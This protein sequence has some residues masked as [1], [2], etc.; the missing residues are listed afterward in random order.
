MLAKDTVGLMDVL[1]IEKAH[2]LGIS[3][4]GL[5]AQQIAISYPERVRS[6]IIVSSHFGGPNQIRMDDR[7]LALLVAVPTET[8][9]F[10]QAR[11]MRYMATFTP[12]FLQENKPLMH[13]MDAWAEKYATPLFAQVN[14]SAATNAFDAEAKLSQI[15]APTLI[16]H[17]DQD[18]AVPTE[19]GRLIA[20]RIPNSKLVI[21]KGAPH[22]CIIEKY[23]ELNNEV[24]NFIDEVEKG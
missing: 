12:K 18:K 19:N 7:T 17:G 16:L 14:Q 2:V 1:G 5:V 9:S 24:M 4:G 21:L 8:I 23:E 3:M 20:K 6:L 11:E 13:Q 10:E 15:A 22:F